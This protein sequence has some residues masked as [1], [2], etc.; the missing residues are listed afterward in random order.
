MGS[1]ARP[2]WSQQKGGLVEELRGWGGRNVRGHGD[3]FGGGRGVAGTRAQQ[4]FTLQASK[5]Q[6]L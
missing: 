1:S 2:G 6:R 5:I 4:D 3:G